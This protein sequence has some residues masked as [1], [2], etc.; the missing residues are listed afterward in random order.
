MRNLTILF[1]VLFSVSLFS[2][3]EKFGK[4]ISLTEKTKISD[5][6][7]DPNAFLDKTV[8]VEGEVLDVCKKAGCWME[9]KS[10]SEGKIKIKV[11][12]GDIVFPTSAIGSKAV[13]E[14]IVYKIELTKEE[15]IEYL[16][17]IAEENGKEFDPA[18]VTGPM[19]IYQIKGIG[20]EI[21]MAKETKSTE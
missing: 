18:S 1:V 12:D 3:V 11:K 8:L 21:E 16:E 7:A 10:D 13:A 4:E 19:T 9:L 2:Q 15:A 5:I 6:L 20:A 14:G 17:H